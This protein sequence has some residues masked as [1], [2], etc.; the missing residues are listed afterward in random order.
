MTTAQWVVGIV[1]LAVGVGLIVFDLWQASRK[2]PDPKA[3]DAALDALRIRVESIVQAVSKVE[4]TAADGVLKE[5]DP[6]ST[7]R[8]G[9]HTFH[10]AAPDGASQTVAVEVTGLSEAVGQVASEEKA[11]T[12][13]VDE[14]KKTAASSVFATLSGTHPLAILGVILMV[15][16]AAS[17]G[18]T[19]DL[20]IGSPTI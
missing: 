16:G 1:F 5:V 3:L 4:S 8:Y 10:L 12:S 15:A 14:V 6:A 19:I 18:V 13:A 17:M 11:V 20:T 2:L 9:V 7:A